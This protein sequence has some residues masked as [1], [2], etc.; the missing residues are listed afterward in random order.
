MDIGV[1]GTQQ[2]SAAELEKLRAVVAHVQHRRHARLARGN[3]ELGVE[4]DAE[5][6]REQ[7]ILGVEIGA[8]QPQQVLR[9]LR[10]RTGA[11]RIGDHRPDAGVLERT[12]ARIAVLG[13]VA[14]L[15]QVDDGGGAHVDQ[16]ERRHE[17]AR[18]NVGGREGGRQQRL[19]VAVVVGVEHAVR[20]D[21]PQHALIGMAVG[22]DEAGN[23][24]PFARV[25]DGD[26]LVGYRHIRPQ[27]ANPPVLDQNVG[28]REIADAAILRQHH[29]A[30]DED[31]PRRQEAGKLRRIG[32]ARRDDLRVGGSAAAGC[33][34]ER[35]G[36]RRRSTGSRGEDGAPRGTL[37]PTTAPDV[38]G[39]LIFPWR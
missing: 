26:G 38:S 30:F 5:R 20:H 35:G 1:A 17:H 27:L 19:N 29:R 18:V 36:W 12:H 16:A 11:A 33:W 2:R 13:R 25:N 32:V 3:E 7:L 4:A 14:D 15:G 24:N 23:D 22:V 6:Q 39:G 8:L 31:A 10:R 21:G 28:A 34:E 37:R 9:I